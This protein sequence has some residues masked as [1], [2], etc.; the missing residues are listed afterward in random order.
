MNTTNMDNLNRHLTEHA[1]LTNRSHLKYTNYA[2][3]K[4]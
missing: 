3:H 2:G 1:K 4:T